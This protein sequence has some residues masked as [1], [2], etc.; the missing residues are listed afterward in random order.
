MRAG[1]DLVRYI[2]AKAVGGRAGSALEYAKASWGDVGNAVKLVEKS[3]IDTAA[4]DGDDDFQ[5]AG[6][7]FLALVRNESLIRKIQALSSFRN[8]PF[9]TPV[10][11]QNTDPLPAWTGEGELIPVAYSAFGTEKL[12]SRKLTGLV[13]STRE[14]MRGYGSTFES[15]I[16]NDLSRPISQLE[17][18][19]FIDPS[20]GGVGEETP[21]SVTNGVTPVNGSSTVK[22]DVAN[23]FAD[24]EGDLESA[25]FVT[26]PKMGL[27]L[28][29]AGY[30]Q[31][32]V[33]G[34]DVAGM[35][36]VTSR[37]V[38]SGVAV[39]LDPSGI[40][41]SDGGI[42]LELAE[43]ASLQVEVNSDEEPVYINLWQENLVGILLRRELNW[44]VAR[45]GSVSFL[46]GATW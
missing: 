10:L 9:H 33:R 43:Q 45:A 17:G 37:S 36:L 35:P 27:A 31:A 15:A 2:Q 19:T 42:A 32:G 41:V 25:V 30:D 16:A 26:S 13:V 38:P 8:I 23:L 1:Y 40:I 28:Y 20:N 21:P 3:V 22:T 39:I 12:P 29:N 4:V 18:E 6:Q 24:F 44:K 11:V 46:A 34:G 14:L 5:A 7:S